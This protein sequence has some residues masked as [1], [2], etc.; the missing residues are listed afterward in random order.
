MLEQRLR[1]RGGVSQVGIDARELFH[2]AHGLAHQVERAGQF[3]IAA[4]EVGLGSLR[5][6]EQRL[7]VSQPA[8]LA[9]EVGILPRAQTGAENLFSLV[10]EHVN[11][12][13]Y[14]AGIMAQLL[15]GGAHAAQR[16]HLCGQLCAQGQEVGVAIEQVHVRARPQ[17]V[18]VLALAVDVDQRPGDVGQQLQADGTAID[19]ADVAARGAHFARQRHAGRV[20]GVIQPF[21]REQ[22]VDVERRTFAVV[23]SIRGRGRGGRGEIVGRCR[24]QEERLNRGNLRAGAHPLAACAVAQQQPHGVDDDRLARARLAREDVQPGAEGE[25][26]FVDDC[27]IAD[28]QLVQHGPILAQ[29]ARMVEARIDD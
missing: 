18:E 3:A 26:Q 8:A 23:P 1:L 6:L 29:L 10:T 22:F 21:S 27:K 2:A 5:Q 9:L 20:V 11:A 7:G 16:R 4:C 12:L 15:Q 25:V 13:G 19:A 14:G 28:V 17:Q 24:Q